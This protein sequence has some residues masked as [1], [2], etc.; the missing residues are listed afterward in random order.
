MAKADGH[1]VYISQRTGEYMVRPGTA[2]LPG[3]FQRGWTADTKRGAERF[4]AELKAED[5][6]KAKA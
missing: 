1:T 2:E 5:Q 6:A 4:M 3:F